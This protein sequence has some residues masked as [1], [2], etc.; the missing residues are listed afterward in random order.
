MSRNYRKQLQI[1]VGLFEP[2]I[3]QQTNNSTI[4]YEGDFQ[5]RESHE[6]IIDEIATIYRHSVRANKDVGSDWL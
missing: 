2:T 4:T 3:R 5:I 6:R 1:R